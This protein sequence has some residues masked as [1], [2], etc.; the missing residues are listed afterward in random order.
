[1][2]IQWVLRVFLFSVV[3]WQ[4]LS[5]S[6]TA[7]W[8]FYEHTVSAFVSLYRDNLQWVVT[9]HRVSDSVSP[10]HCIVTI[11]IISW[12]DIVHCIVTALWTH[13][14]W[15]CFSFSVYVSWQSLF[16]HD[17][18]LENG[19]VLPLI[20]RDNLHYIVTLLLQVSLYRDTTVIIFIISWHLSRQS[21]LYL[22]IC[23]YNLH[24]IFDIYRDNLHNILTSIAT[25]FIISWQLSRRS[26]L[27][28]DTNV[29]NFI[30]CWNYRDKPFFVLS[31][32]LEPLMSASVFP[33]HCIVT[34]FLVSR[35]SWKTLVSTV[36]SFLFSVV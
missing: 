9:L 25:I 21:S 29:T 35:Q 20:C 36:L 13:N 22:D 31:Q 3:S 32:T 4:S 15:F 23:Q 10:L 11:F 27:C 12:H 19:S 2:T 14:G 5:Y 16:H 28:C 7:F 1:M 34:T 33:L 26:L 24:Y 30:V 8:S 18:P 6:D 17:N